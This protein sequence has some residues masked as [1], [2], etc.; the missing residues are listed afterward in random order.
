MIVP[1]PRK[2]W[3]PWSRS[4]TTA[5]KK[6]LFTIEVLPSTTEAMVSS[7]SPIVQTE[8]IGYLDAPLDRRRTTPG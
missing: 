1:A 7:H 6:R 4:S 8:T 2:E 3:N 5:N